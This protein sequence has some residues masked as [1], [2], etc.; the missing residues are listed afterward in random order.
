MFAHATEPGGLATQA[1]RFTL[2]TTSHVANNPRLVKEADALTAAGVRVR[3]VAPLQLRGLAQRDD[4]LLATRRWQLLRVNVSRGDRCGRFRW[5]RDA[6]LERLA[7][8]LLALGVR[9]PAVEDRAISRHL[10]S[11]LAEATAEPAETVIA[12]NVQALPIAARAAAR[13]GARLGFDV[14]DLHTGELPETEDH[15][16]QRELVAAVEGRYLPRCAL[17]T[18]SSEGIADAVAA[19]YGVAR[20]RVVLNVFPRT[21]RERNVPCSRERPAGARVSL[22]WYSQVIGAGRG[23][24]E[25]LRALVSLP[26]DVHLVLRG[27]SDARFAAWLRDESER[28]GVRARLHLR[29]AAPPDQLVAL[30]ACHDVGLALEQPRTRNRDLCVTN[31]IF[32]YLLAGL[33]VAATDTRGQRGIMALTGGAGFLYAAGDDQALAR[34]LRTLTDSADRLAAARERSRLAAEHRFNWDVEQETLVSYLLAPRPSGGARD[35]ACV[36]S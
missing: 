35:A 2:V 30:A 21:D 34:E 15:A 28:L 6:L 24:E 23:I 10:D 27:G 11:L 4:E 16:A 17:L 22:Y 9:V 8:R 18:A 31:K 33:A 14:E 29:V 26:A 13:L 7:H 25:A 20:P 36:A 1:P 3:V 5:L 12:H 19:T 32:T